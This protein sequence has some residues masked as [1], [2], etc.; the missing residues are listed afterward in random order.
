MTQPVPQ[1]LDRSYRALVAVPR[2]GR[3]LLAMQIA[4]VAQSMVGVALV[5]FTLLEYDS[6]VLAGAVTF[7]SIAPGLVV[8]PIAGALL[9]RHGRV[10]L[11]T[12]DYLVALAALVML[13]VLALA[14]LLPPPLLLLIAAV[15]SLTSILSHT[16]LRSLFPLI[17]PRHLW[18][19]VN[20]IDSNGYVVATILGP[21]IAAGS[22]AVFGGPTALLAVGLSF[23][24]AAVAMIGVPDPPSQNT[25]TGNLML[26]AW[27]GLVYTWR[28]RTLR[29][30]G[31]AISTLNIAGG[32]G[33]IVVPLIVLNR[34][35]L[36]EVVVGGVFAVSGIAGMGS[37]LLFGRIDSRGREWRMLVWPMV[38]MAPAV[39]L[40]L[41]A[42][43]SVPVGLGVAT[44]LAL[45]GASLAIGGLLNGPLDIALFTVRQRRTEPAWMGRAFAVSM[46]FNFVGYPLGAALGGIVAEFSLEAAIVIGVA[47]CLIAAVLAAT[48]V[49]KQEVG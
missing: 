47:A 6:P 4:R 32:I 18:E 26:D 24:I 48:M 34:L 22:V 15:S 17:V 1:D 40:L 20:A 41:A 19:R 37:A 13:G 27:H 11:I 42:A 9:D 38:A 49:P 7:L 30:L 43:V 5:L 44:G 35:G 45:T 39:A 23:G 36:G 31:F 12:L 46:A 14:K 25:S 8:S 21:P 16:G 10:R 33:T 3:T 29:G 2:L 28:N